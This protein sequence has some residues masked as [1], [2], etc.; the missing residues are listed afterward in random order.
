MAAGADM[1]ELD[2]RLTRCGEVVV[3]HDATFARMCGSEH[4]GGVENTDFAALP[5]LSQQQQRIPRLS[6]VL[7]LIGAHTPLIVEFKR[8]DHDLV[9]KTHRLLQA[10]GHRDAGTIVWFGL[11]GEINPALRA[12]D[13]AIPTL[14]SIPEMLRTVAAH[15]LGLAPLLPAALLAPFAV[16]G[17]PV[18][19]VDFARVRSNKTFATCP[20]W[21]LRAAVTVAG[22]DP[23]KAFLCGALVRHL[24]DARGVPTW[25]LGVNDRRQLSAVRGAGASAVLCDRPEWLAGVLREEGGAAAGAAKGRPACQQ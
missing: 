12:C 5:P 21:L 25:Y 17:L 15:Y 6:D 23:C 9:L 11:P 19:R 13:P 22:G 10:S 14:P 16:F 7:A 4:V 18:D 2:V 1:V 24:R 8:L 20:D 3:F